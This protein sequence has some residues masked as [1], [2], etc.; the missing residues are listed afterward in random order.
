MYLPA[1]DAVIFSTWRALT[2][3]LHILKSYSFCNIQLKQPT[4]RLSSHW[5]ACGLI[6]FVVSLSR[7]R[8]VPLGF[9]TLSNNRSDSRLVILPKYH[10]GEEGGSWRWWARLLPT[11]SASPWNVAG[12]LGSQ[13]TP[14]GPEGSSEPAVMENKQ[15]GRVGTH[16]SAWMESEGAT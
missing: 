1:F 14:S 4:R 2:S 3:S 5:P 8:K 16:S 7:T 11:H 9:S 12:A 15:E 6:P 10:L 13:T